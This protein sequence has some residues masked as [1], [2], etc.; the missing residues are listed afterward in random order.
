MIRRVI[1]L[2]H[3]RA[4]GLVVLVA[5]AVAFYAFD[6]PDS[7]KLIGGIVLG[8]AWLALYVAVPI[9]RS[10]ARRRVK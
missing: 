7:L 6:L 1:S 3:M 10:V 4:V 9:I 2:D 8:A 5:Y